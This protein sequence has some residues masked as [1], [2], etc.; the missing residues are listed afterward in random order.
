MVARKRTPKKTTASASKK[1]N[2]LQELSWVFEKFGPAQLKDIIADIEKDIAQSSSL[3]SQESFQEFVPKNPN[4]MFLVGILPRIFSDPKFFETN[5]EIANFA[6]EI[7]D[8]KI[9][10]WEKKSRF[11]LIGHIVCNVV[12]ANDNKLGQ[13]AQALKIM[14]KKGDDGDAILENSRKGKKNW[15][16]I[17]QLLL[18]DK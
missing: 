11:E 12:G 14:L 18:S 2:F 4:Q 5:E 8:V 17:I 10:N 16:E 15:N 1:I 7:L 13:I 6:N 9:S 3:Q